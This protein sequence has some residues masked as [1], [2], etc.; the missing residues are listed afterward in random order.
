MPPADPRK[1]SQTARWGGKLRALR[2]REGLTQKELAAR[3][4]ISPSYLNLIENDRRP[5]TAKL[6]VRL[7]QT[8]DVDLSA[9][10]EQEDAALVSDLMEVFS[11]PALEDDAISNVDVRELAQSA[12]AA[13]RAVLSLYRHLDAARAQNQALATRLLGD[14][15]PV[16]TR[17]TVPSEEVSDFLQEQRNH[18]AALE[19]AAEDLWHKADL[20]SDRLFET[21]KAHLADQLGVETVISRGPDQPL[22]QFD[23]KSHTLRLSEQLAPRSRHFQMAHQV[24]LLEHKTLLDELAQSS[25]V[26]SPESRALGKV[27]LANYFAGAVLMPYEAFQK[28]AEDLRYDIELLGHRFRVSFEQVCHR[29]TNLSRP[30]QEGVPFHFIRVDVAGNISKRFSGSGIRFARFSGACPRWNVFSAFATPGRFRIQVS[31]MEDGQRFF[32]VA[33]TVSNEARG[34]HAPHVVHAVGLGCDVSHAHKMVYADGLRLDDQDHI[35]PVGVT[36]RLCE[37]NRCIQR[38]VPS[39][40]SP[41]RV[42]ENL[43]R[44]SFYASGS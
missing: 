8:L 17:A 32:C 44:S 19:Q 11:D 20:D 7:S 12:P 15:A 13:A 38:A 29:L 42:D 18:F 4:E 6:L 26:I 34:Y 27:A 10:S 23:K 31:E 39:L 28:A 16:A 21:L 5:L 43:R 14:A 33:R 2:R 36:C 24:A 37:R 3:L 9:F 35:I 41:L 30:G 22:R 1:D 25:T 40:S